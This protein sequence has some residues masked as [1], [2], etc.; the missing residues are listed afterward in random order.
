MGAGT[1]RGKP[2]GLCGTP[3]VAPK[4]RVCVL[5]ENSAEALGAFLGAHPPIPQFSQGLK[6]S[7]CHH[8]HSWVPPIRIF[9]I[10]PSQLWQN[11]KTQPKSTTRDAHTT[12]WDATWDAQETRAHTQH[13]KHWEPIFLGPGSSLSTQLTQ[14]RVK[15]L[16]F[17]SIWSSNKQ[18]NKKTAGGVCLLSII[19]RVLWRGDPCHPPSLRCRA[20]L[21][22]PYGKGGPKTLGTIKQADKCGE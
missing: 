8:F 1:C 7:Q 3:R 21:G 14:S 9:N 4:A 6:A 12:L 11:H 20:W 18:T 13:W 17:C 2:V 22:H 16:C 10:P 15:E 5:R 19:H